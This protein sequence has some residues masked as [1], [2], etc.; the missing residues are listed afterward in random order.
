MYEMIYIPAALFIQ[1]EQMLQILAI[2]IHCASL[3]EVKEGDSAK[4]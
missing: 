1:S 4:R 3:G 2:V